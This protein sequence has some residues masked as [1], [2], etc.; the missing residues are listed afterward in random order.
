MD[1]ANVS[2]DHENDKNFV[3][4]KLSIDKTADYYLMIWTCK[5]NQTNKYHY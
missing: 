5:P 2:Y 3:G 1:S 4:K